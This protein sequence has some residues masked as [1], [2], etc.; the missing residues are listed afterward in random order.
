RAVSVGGLGGRRRGP[1]GRP[2]VARRGRPGRRHRPPVPG[3]GP[4]AAGEGGRGPPASRRRPRGPGAE[5]PLPR[6]AAL[7]GRSRRPARRPRRGEA[8]TPP[9]GP[10]PP[11]FGSDNTTGRVNKKDATEQY[12]IRA[13]VPGSGA[14]ANEQLAHLVRRVGSAVLLQAGAQIPDGALL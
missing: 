13:S 9:E 10:R 4:L 7:P 8:V 3:D 14:M 1:G 2:Q 12:Y 6:R 11:C 5:G